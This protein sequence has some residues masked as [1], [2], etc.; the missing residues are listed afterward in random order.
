MTPHSQTDEAIE[1]TLAALREVEPTAGIQ[2]RILANL[3]TQATSQPH[4]W[5]GLLPQFAFAMAVASL[6]ILAINLPLLRPRTPIVARSIIPSQA[7]YYAVATNP[8]AVTTSIKPPVV[9]K[10]RVAKAV[11]MMSA[12]SQE[13]E[14]LLSELHAPS[15]PAPPLPLTD[16]EKHLLH[17]VTIAGPKPLDILNAKIRD[18]EMAASKAEFQ[19]FFAQSTVKFDEQN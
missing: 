1:R 9:H 5:R 13:D 10:V 18:Q 7:K 16:E 3:E 17:I 15:M 12:T 14:L 6:V 8:T 11:S 2:Q 19:Q 4:A